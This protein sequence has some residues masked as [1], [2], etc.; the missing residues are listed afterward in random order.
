MFIQFAS[1]DLKGR[2]LLGIS[3]LVLGL[4][5]LLLHGVPDSV[6]SDVDLTAAALPSLQSTAGTKPIS[7]EVVKEREGR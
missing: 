7:L 3:G 1:K 4:G 6:P 5:F 2:S